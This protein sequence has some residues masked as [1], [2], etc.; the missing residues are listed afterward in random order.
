MSNRVR[1]AYETAAAIA[2][3]TRAQ[4][5]MRDHE[6]TPGTMIDL[7]DALEMAML[8]EQIKW[9]DVFD[10]ADAREV[11]TRVHALALKVLPVEGGVN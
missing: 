8:A 7:A 3:L 11:I 4:A 10:E 1:L 2:V 6:P 5:H 9:L